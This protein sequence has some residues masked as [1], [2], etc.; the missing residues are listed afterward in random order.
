M[1]KIRGFTEW[2]CT[3]NDGEKGPQ[4]QQSAHKRWQLFLR[5][6]STNE[7][8]N[9]RIRIHLIIHSNVKKVEEKNLFSSVEGIKEKKTHQT[10]TNGC[11]AF[12]QG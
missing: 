2:V 8:K 10:L 4:T 6:M 3:I 5:P 11:D 1:Q 9:Q 12:I 7:E